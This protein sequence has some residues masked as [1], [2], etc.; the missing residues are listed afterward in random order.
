[1]AIWPCVAAR[2]GAARPGRRAGRRDGGVDGVARAAV[3]VAGNR[4]GD[5]RSAG[6]RP[7]PRP[8]SHAAR[9]CAARGRGRGCSRRAC[10]DAGLQRRRRG[11]GQRRRRS[12]RRTRGASGDAGGRARVGLARG[13]RA[14]SRLLARAL[15]SGTD[16]WLALALRWSCSRL[17]SP[18]ASQTA[19]GQRWT[20][21]GTHSFTLAK[22][23][24]SDSDLSLHPGGPVAA[25][26]GRRQSLR[27]LAHRLAAVAKPPAG[28]C[29]R[30]QLCALVL[31]TPRNDRGRTAAAFARVA[32]PVGARARGGLAARRVAGG[33]WGSAA[34]MRVGAKRSPLVRAL[35]VGGLGTFTAWVVQ[36]SVDWMQ[37]L[38]GL[39]AV[40][41]AACAVLVWP[42]RQPRRRRRQ[43]RTGR[44][45][46]AW[47]PG[48]R[49]RRRGD[50]ATLVTA[51]A[52]LTRQ[53][54]ADHFRSRA[55][56][57]LRETAWRRS[58]TSTA[59]STSTATPLSPT[60]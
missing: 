34:R 7:R 46:L 28:R 49:A 58:E 55:R 8:R 12:R 37:L 25:A 2:R 56:S 41:L 22:S 33:G 54:L 32:N 52:S 27:L 9:V 53:G 51:G 36:A 29:R 47:R 3:A 15:A 13:A 42:R 18:S 23:A 17:P 59:R 4:R 57:E 38:P 14:T 43:S 31:R 11:A 16:A 21:S 35:M 44:R 60:T 30:G 10:A 50:R 6:S 24:K 26:V 40:A 5:R 19:S 45:S 1:M 39:T 48:D 20:G